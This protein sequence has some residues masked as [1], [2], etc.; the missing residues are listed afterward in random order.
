[1]IVVLTEITVVEVWWKLIM[2]EAYGMSFCVFCWHPEAVCNGTL[3]EWVN[4]I[5]TVYWHKHYPHTQGQRS[6]KLALWSEESP[7][8]EK[9]AQGSKVLLESDLPFCK[10]NLEKF[11]LGRTHT[12]SLTP[13]TN[14]CWDLLC[15]VKTE[16]WDSVRMSVS[17]LFFSF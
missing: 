6:A 13:L 14:Q 10:R 8:I 16:F 5:V 12:H 11:S 2:I 7:Q 3:S 1:M 9:V 4:V 17:S 15:K